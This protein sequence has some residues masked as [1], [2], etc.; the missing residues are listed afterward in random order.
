M[1]AEPPVRDEQA[2]PGDAAPMP[3]APAPAVTARCLL[4][5]LALIPL[6][7]YWVGTTEGVW[8]GLHFTCLSLPMT[9]VFYLLS[10]QLANLALLRWRPKRALTQAELLTIFSMLALSGIVCGHDRLVTL[11]GTVAHHRRFATPENG[12]ERLIFP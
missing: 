2:A 6:N 3:L 5:G 1:I 4:I 9:A 11:M 12:W 10:L 7:V 8:H